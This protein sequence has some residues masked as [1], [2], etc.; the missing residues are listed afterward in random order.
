MNLVGLQ[1][2]LGCIDTDIRCVDPAGSGSAR[3]RVAR[4]ELFKNLSVN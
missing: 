4:A 1:G 2:H 3:I